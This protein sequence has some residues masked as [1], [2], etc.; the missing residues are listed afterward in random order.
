MKRN[1]IVFLLVLCLLLGGCEYGILFEEPAE[2]IPVPSAGTLLEHGL[3]VHFIDVGQA[4]AILL[5]CDGEYMLID[6]GNKDDSRLVV[7]YLENQGVAELEA[8]VCTHAHEDHVGGLPAVL[9]V[10]PT[11]R[12]YAPTKTYASQIFDSFLHYADQQRLEMTIPE[13]GDSWALGDA[14]VTVLGPVKSY[15]EPNNTSIVLLVEYGTNRFLFTG[16]ME[17]EAET[18]MLEYWD[19][20]L[21]WDVDVLK[22]GHHGSN[23]S[24]GYRFLYETRPEYGVVSVGREN[25]YGHPSGNIMERYRDAGTAIFRTDRLGDVIAQ[26]DGDRVIF[27]WENQKAEPENG[28]DVN[29]M[30]YV[31]NT[32]SHVFHSETCRPLPGESKRIYFRNFLDALAA[33]YRPCSGCLE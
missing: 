14:A 17:L 22:L 20:K 1:S 2:T 3:T 29:N 21:D 8:V 4:D 32:S 13:P 26:S 19:G 16:D 23:T 7:S 27:L 12:V 25:T 18:D 11:R 24:S 28:L 30:T 10:Y 31:G 9:A 33:G 15:A 5:A 6:G